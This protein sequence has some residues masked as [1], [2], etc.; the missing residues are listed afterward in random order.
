MR[1]SGRKALITGA[2]SGIGRAM[3]LLF[4]REGAD[5]AVNDVRQ[6]RIERVV[7]E[8]RGLGRDSVGVQ[9]D[10]TDLSAVLAGTET[11]RKALGN[12]D[13]LCANAGIAPTVKFVDMTPEAFDRMIKVHL[14][15][16][17]NCCKAV[18]DDMVRRRFGR[19][20]VTS[21]MSGI[22]GDSWL[23]HYSAAKAGQI[24]FVKSLAREL[25]ASGI[26]VN[27][28]APGL[29]LTNIQADVSQEVLDK[30]MPPCGRAGHPEDQGWAAVYLASDEAAFVTGHTLM[31]NGGSF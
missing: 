22:A 5:V 18:V 12:I 4:A 20:I 19:I 16:A 17:F 3:A 14:Y 2:G 1:L 9:F 29:T 30:Y 23:A 21:S 24:A 10:V 13:V 28:I 27:A 11:A 8:V 7:A 25:A 26:T 6:D 31:V 15:G